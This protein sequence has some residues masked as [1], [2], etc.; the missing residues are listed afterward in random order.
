V[1]ARE[2]RAKTRPWRQTPWVIIKKTRFNILENL[3]FII[4]EEDNRG[5]KE[6]VDL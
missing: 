6:G 5:L 2:I 4:K 1:T 3:P